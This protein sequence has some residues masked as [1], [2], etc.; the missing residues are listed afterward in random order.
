METNSH[1][2]K[3][4]FFDG[5]QSRPHVAFARLSPDRSALEVTLGEQQQNYP[6]ASLRVSDRL[7]GV[8]R[9]IEFETGYLESDDD[10]CI[11]D[12][13]KRGVTL[14]GRIASI[15]RRRSWVL[16][17]ALTGLLAF[18]LLIQF[19]LPALAG[20]IARQIPRSVET[21][22]G[23]RV[24]DLLDNLGFAESTLKA[25]RKEHLQALFDRMR[26]HSPD[27]ELLKL[28]FRDSADGA[29]AFALPGG[30]VV[31]TDGMAKLTVNDA[32]FLS[33]VGHEL[34]HQ[35]ARDPLKH[36]I[37]SATLNFLLISLTGDIT[38][39][40]L[41]TAQVG[42]IIDA[43]HSKRAEL[44][45]DDFAFDQ[46]RTLGYSPIAFAEVMEKFARDEEGESVPAYFSSHPPSKDRAERAR[47]AARRV[48]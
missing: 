25:A 23:A 9:R 1:A 18:V 40:V 17:L 39:V 19:G 11:D 31:V 46:L 5:K 10:D 14:G 28:H 33:I 15:E 32:Q 8:P 26:A 38:T 36:L 44:A 2:L 48:E 20:M 37:S 4:R 42:S 27:R 7:A 43:S 13:F 6:L 30:A 22:L 16:T 29:N 47:A 21:A 34:G 35:Q 3:V 41:S 45:A 24:L 12:W